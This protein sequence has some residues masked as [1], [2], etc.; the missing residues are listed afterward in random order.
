MLENIKGLTPFIWPFNHSLIVNAIIGTCQCSMSPWT[1]SCLRKKRKIACL[2]AEESMSRYE[3]IFATL[4]LSLYSQIS[5]HSRSSLQNYGI[6]RRNFALSAPSVIT[7]RLSQ[8]PGTYSDSLNISSNSTCII[9][10]CPY[11]S[12]LSVCYSCA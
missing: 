9:T 7:S 4:L 1:A 2:H 3:Q 6:Y 5:Q 10:R 11:I 12:F 8:K